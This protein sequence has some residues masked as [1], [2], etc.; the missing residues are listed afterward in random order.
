MDRI[1]LDPWVH[2]LD[3]IWSAKLMDPRPTLNWTLSAT[4]TP[5][6]RF[7]APVCWNHLS[8]WYRPISALNT[9]SCSCRC[10]YSTT[11]EKIMSRRWCLTFSTLEIG[12]LDSSSVVVSGNSNPS[13]S[14]EYCNVLYR[15]KPATNHKNTQLLHILKSINDVV[16]AVWLLF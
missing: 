12:L 7:Q 16:T 3:W 9:L 4:R 8:A 11:S 1:G 5:K 14:A 6:R 10:C 13:L 15:K 2:E